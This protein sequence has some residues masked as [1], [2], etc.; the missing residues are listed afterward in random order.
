VQPWATKKRA[1]KLLSVY[2]SQ[3]LTDFQQSFTGALS[4]KFAMT[5]LLNISPHLTC[6]ARS[7]WIAFGRRQYGRLPPSHVKMLWVR[8]RLLIV[9]DV[10]YASCRRSVMQWRS[11]DFVLRLRF[12]QREFAPDSKDQTHW[13]E[14]RAS[15]HVKRRV[16]SF[17]RFLRNELCDWRADRRATLRWKP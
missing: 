12:I 2:I 15:P 16:D 10:L 8:C 4:G 1:T 6:V 3:I 9:V 13:Q 17:G 5:S 7:R 11:Q 14:G